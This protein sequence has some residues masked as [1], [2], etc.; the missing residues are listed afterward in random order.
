ML[1]IFA[2]LSLPLHA[3]KHRSRR[4]SGDAAWE[5]A[6]IFPIP[7]STYMWTAQK[8]DG[9]YADPAMKLIAMPASAATADALAALEE[10]ADKIF[11]NLPCTDLNHGDVF[12]P[13]AD[14]CYK[15]LF[16][17]DL[18]QSL[19]TLDARNHNFVAFFAEHFPTEFESN[20]HYLK[21]NTGEDVEP[22]AELP[23][24]E[25]E[26]GDSADWGAS[27]AAALIVN[28]MTLAGVVLAAPGIQS[29]HA[30]YADTVEG[31][32]ASFAAGA[33]LACAF[34]LLLF[35]STHLIA[36]KWPDPDDEVEVLWRWGTM[37][38]AGFFIPAVIE[39]GSILFMGSKA[40]A[41][42]GASAPEAAVDAPAETNA[43]EAVASK[44]PYNPSRIRVIGAVLLGDFM[45]NLCDGF[46]I[47][48]AFKVCGGGFAWGVTLGTV[49]HELPQEL[50]D[51]GILVGRE[52]G[53]KPLVALCWNFLAGLSVILGVIIVNAADVGQA[54]TGLLLAFGG[55]VY[56]YLAAVVCMPKVSLLKTSLVYSLAGL[57]AF[58][59]GCVIIGLILLDHKHCAAEGDHGHGGH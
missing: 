54:D 4:L 6:G 45:H 26:E 12:V 58:V 55:G 7:D 9:A 35:E 36:T 59:I 25:E 32:F 31:I 39:T 5:W 56:V 24:A 53:W 50:A 33:L 29:L 22:E 34:F 13:S 19:Y 11:E 3:R 20:A 21:D 18:W 47:G 37:I 48:A 17:N 27:I 46:F 10:D 14:A 42:K 41:E 51:Y 40:S 43:D 30:K 38:L 57:L 16:N 23:D 1:V 15:L 49:L 52:V 28:L 8:V 2:A 44:D